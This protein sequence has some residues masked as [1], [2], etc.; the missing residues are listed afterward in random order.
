MKLTLLSLLFVSTVLSVVQAVCQTTA[1]GYT[2]NFQG[3]RDEVL[4]DVT[5]AESCMS[6]CFDNL[7]CAGYTWISNQVV[8]TCY[9]FHALDDM[10][11]CYKC[12]SGALPKQTND[13]SFDGAPEM[14]VVATDTAMDCFKACAET[15]GCLGY[16]WYDP[17]SQDPNSCYLYSDWSSTGSCEQ[18]C[19]SGI[20]NCIEQLP[21]LIPD[22]CTNY[23]VMDDPTRNMNYG[24]YSDYCDADWTSTSPD[25]KGKA[26]YRIQEPAG[27]RIPTGGVSYKH[28]GTDG[29]GWIND[30][31]HKIPNMQVGEE[32]TVK[33][34]YQWIHDSCDEEND[35]RVTKCPGDYLVYYLPSHGKVCNLRYCATF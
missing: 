32:V 13:A 2:W 22:Q 24:D 12:N 27:V 17:E 5:S 21:L 33:V 18:S 29:A 25:W 7:D 4:Y 31:E 10:H 34:C 26:Y 19:T 15:E 16:T 30:Y 8:D 3:G 1:E 11:Q 28:C 23:E 6:V 14:A 35:I 20:M 9:L